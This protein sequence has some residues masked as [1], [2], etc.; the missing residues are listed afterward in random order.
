MFG[1]SD[2]VKRFGVL[3]TTAALPRGLRITSRRHLLARQELA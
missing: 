3:L 2:E 1:V